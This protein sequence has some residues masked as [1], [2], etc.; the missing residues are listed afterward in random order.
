MKLLAFD[1]SMQA[2]SAAVLIDSKPA[3]EVVA[4]HRF[5]AMSQGHAERLLPMIGEVLDEAGLDIS[6][7]DRI[8]VTRGPGSFTGVRIGVATARALALATG[9]EAIG[10]SSLRVI[11]ADYL[12]QSE[13]LTAEAFAIAIDARRGQVYFQLFAGLEPRS[14]PLALSPCDAARLLPLGQ[15]VTLLGSGGALL[16]EAAE[17]SLRGALSLAP[18]RDGNPLPRAAA[19]ARLARHLPSATAPLSP[20]YLRPP[21]AKVQTG[22]ALDRAAQGDRR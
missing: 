4:A 3:G 15:R 21:D 1:T 10:E 12:E 17:A 6:D 16:I 8:A 5:E 2:C 7:I 13:S 20:L 9:A 19:L 18:F 22:Y 11:A 14:E